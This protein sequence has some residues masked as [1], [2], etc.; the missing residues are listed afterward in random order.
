MR[1]FLGVWS[2]FPGLPQ[3]GEQSVRRSRPRL[4]LAVEPLERRDVPAT[5]LVVPLSVAT[6]ATHFHDL[7]SAV[8]AAVDNDIIQIEPN[9]APGGATI[10]KL[11][12]IQGEP[13]SSPASLP[14]LGDLT[15][16]ASGDTLQNL[17]LHNVTINATFNNTTITSSL[18]A[19]I[20]DSGG[21]GNGFTTLR[22]NVFTDAV[23]LA[24]NTAGATNDL[25]ENN[26]FARQTTS[27][28]TVTM[29]VARAN[30]TVIQG[31]TVT[32]SN[33]AGIGVSNSTNV[34]ILN[35]IVRAPNAGLGGIVVGFVVLSGVS[36][37]VTIADNVVET[38]S[39]TGIF[40]AK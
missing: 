14:Q 18:A 17:N 40:L 34:S 38:G 31:N 36:T 32:T 29:S 23:F 2:R 7:A 13:T 9:S 21:S 16:A 39:G 22:N 5:L 6:D 25:V 4:R 19:A 28:F 33:F 24:G 30:G 8:S 26:V 3:R 10:N 1:R 11:L 35:N 15:I 27:G 12:T 37:S 20:T